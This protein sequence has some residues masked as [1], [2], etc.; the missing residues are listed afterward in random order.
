ME[1]REFRFADRVSL[2]GDLPTRDRQTSHSSTKA[3]AVA[4]AWKRVSIS[5]P[6]R[7]EAAGDSLKGG[8][9]TKN[10]C[11]GVQQWRARLSG[12]VWVGRLR[13][14]WFHSPPHRF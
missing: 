6:S 10:W 13:S 11:G 1:A 4:H 3:I 5:R 14:G 7:P 9:W 2:L 8:R 12:R